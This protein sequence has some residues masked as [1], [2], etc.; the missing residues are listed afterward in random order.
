MHY[1]SRQTLADQ[2]YQLTELFL[3]VGG[4][5]TFI[6]G[7]IGILNFINSILTG[8]VTRQQEFAMLEA[9]GMTK[10]QLSKMLVLEGVYYALGTIVFSMVFGCLFSFTALRVLTNGMWFMQYHFVIWPMLVVF[11][12]LLLLG[13][14]VPKAA[15]CLGK[16]E[17]VVERL[18]K[19][20]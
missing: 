7:L 18:R 5:L 15:I 14:G 2:F 19:S 4:V 9:I 20:R 13:Y 3:L 16:K 8:I 10:R 17:S 11:P 12:A 6:V 1:E